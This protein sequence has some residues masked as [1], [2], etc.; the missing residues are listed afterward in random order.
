M[1][2]LM[3]FWSQCLV[4]PS[5]VAACTE[6]YAFLSPGVSFSTLLYPQF[7]QSELIRPS[8]HLHRVHLVYW[9]SILSK[10]HE[11]KDQ[12]KKAVHVALRG[13][14]PRTAHSILCLTLNHYMTVEQ[15]HNKNFVMYKKERGRF[16]FTSFELLR[17]ST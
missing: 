5:A 11:W 8:P 15:G 13:K 4:P 6:W 9:M 7:F 16:V 1:V 10:Q 12:T 14:H 3:W 17:Q 2:M